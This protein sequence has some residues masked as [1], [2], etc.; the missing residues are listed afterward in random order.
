MNP[1]RRS[2]G[3]PCGP[4]W[5]ADLLEGLGDELGDQRWLLVRGEV[6]RAGDGDQAYLGALFE[7]APFLVGDPAV[8]ALAVDYP[9][10]H[11]G[12]H[13]RDATEP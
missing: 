8:A 13:S 12:L 7:G 2:G 4:S 10:W 5:S 9:G 1:A 6:A 11:A 3:G